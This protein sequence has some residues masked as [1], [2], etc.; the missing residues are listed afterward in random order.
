MIENTKNVVIIFLKKKVGYTFLFSMLK[1]MSIQSFF[2]CQ[3]QTNYQQPDYKKYILER[4][5]K[6]KTN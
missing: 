2:R 3:K 5:N 1:Q 6:I 4:K